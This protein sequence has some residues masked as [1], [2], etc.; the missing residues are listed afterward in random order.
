[1]NKRIILREL[2][3]NLNSN[4]ISNDGYYTEVSG[5][6][7]DNIVTLSIHDK[8]SEEA[9]IDLQVVYVDD[10]TELISEFIDKLMKQYMV[11]MSSDKRENSFY[12][13]IL[14]MFLNAR[15]YLINNVA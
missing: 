11:D 15:E 14:E 4:W 13:E 12:Y 9:I 6:Y 7:F 3:R 10:I 5:N 1:M 8:K 2:E